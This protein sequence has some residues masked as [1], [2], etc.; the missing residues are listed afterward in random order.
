VSPIASSYPALN[1]LIAVLLGAWPNLFQWA[2]L[3][4][5]MLGVLIVAACARAFEN[6]EGYAPGH[7]RKTVWIAIGAAGCFTLGIMTGQEA[8]AFYG[9]TATLAVSRGIGVVACIGLLIALR[10]GIRGPAIYWPL[11]LLQGAL[12]GV[13]Y[14][15]LLLGGRGTEG[16]IT[17]TVA[18]GFAVVTALLARIFLKEPVTAKQWIGIFLVALGA[19]ALAGN[20]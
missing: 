8:S 17:V 11:V 4:V 15:C 1:L 3:L 14:L 6:G 2:A 12:D 18:S 5:V 13:A 16:V 20:S 19:G 7:V 9:E 10:Q